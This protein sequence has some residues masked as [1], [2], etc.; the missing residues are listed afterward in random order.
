MRAHRFGIGCGIALTLVATALPAR[1]QDDTA[2]A[3]TLFDQ[4]K[5]LADAQNYAEACPKFFDSYA[6]TPKLGTLLN[7]ADCYEKI[8][9][10][11]S[12]WARFSEA[13]AMAE[14]AKEGERAAFAKQHADELVK[15]LATLTITAPNAP[16]HLQITRDG[17]ALDPASLD[18][19]VPVDPG[20]HVIVAS[21]P[22]KIAWTLT[23]IVPKSAAQRLEIP[24]LETAPEPPPAALPPPCEDGDASCGRAFKTK[25]TFLQLHVAAATSLGG[26][27]GT[28]PSALYG[29]GTRY[30]G[31][32]Y[33]IGGGIEGGV[34]FVLGL[35]PLPAG[36]AGGFSAVVI[37]PVIGAYGGA[38]LGFAPTTDQS[39]GSGDF[40][41]RLGVTL[42]FQLLH[43]GSRN[44]DTGQQY[45]AGFLVGYRPALQYAYVQG[46]FQ[47]NRVSFVH[48]PI[49]A[50]VFPVYFP[51]STHLTRALLEV[52][53]LHIPALPGYFVTFGGGVAF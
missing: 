29:P 37:E 19:A 31:A 20:A 36:I 13:I 24:A 32:S 27:I 46:Y 48:G 33:R 6:L 41:L 42:A 8:G 51:R 53:F 11:A 16:P 22:K 40:F 47:E 3:L 2:L 9:K 18:V 25:R 49:L 35:K 5:R 17:T 45:G 1:A 43:I 14:G 21:A 30:P 10:T 38:T 34:D 44:V 12:A 39:K 15:S 7:L 50:G 52:A 23:V 26:F 28:P 4:G